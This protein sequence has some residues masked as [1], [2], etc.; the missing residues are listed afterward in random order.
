ME[1][2]KFVSCINRRV[3]GEIAMAVMMQAFYWDAAVKE[4][5]VGE[6]WNFVAEKGEHAKLW[7]A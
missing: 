4:N 6:W 5:K 1:I 7:A 3:K 2:W